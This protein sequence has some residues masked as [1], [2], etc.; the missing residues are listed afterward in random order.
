VNLDPRDTGNLPLIFGLI[1][2]E[3]RRPKRPGG[4]GGGSL[5]LLVWL[6]FALALAGSVL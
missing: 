1:D 4:C 2:D 3:R 6:A 5:A